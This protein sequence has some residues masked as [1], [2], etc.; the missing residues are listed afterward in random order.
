MLAESPPIAGVIL[1][2]GVLRQILFDCSQISSPLRRVFEHLSFASAKH[3]QFCLHSVQSCVQRRQLLQWFF[4]CRLVV[5]F[6]VIVAFVNPVFVG[7]L[8]IQV[9]GL[10]ILKGRIA[11]RQLTAVFPRNFQRLR[12]SLRHQRCAGSTLSKILNP[13]RSGLREWG[14]IRIYT[15]MTLGASDSP[16]CPM[17]FRMRICSPL[18]CLSS[19]GRLP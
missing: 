9:S 17:K 14:L 12:R 11:S 13:V 16:H 2:V 5:V 15:G 10:Q 8:V 1:P 19:V 18:L 7:N 3:A 6:V 4:N